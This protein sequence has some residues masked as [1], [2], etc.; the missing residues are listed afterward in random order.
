MWI[1][2]SF[3]HFLC[4]RYERGNFNLDLGSDIDETFDVE[5]R[6]GREMSPDRL[7]PGS[8][9]PGAGG[10]IFA[11]AGQIPGQAND[12]LGPG[13]GLSE[14]LDDPSQRRPHLPRHN[15]LLV[16]LPVAAGLAG[17]D[18]P[19]ARTIDRDAVR[20]AAWLC[21][22]CR[23]QDTHELVLQSL[24]GI[25]ISGRVNRTR[26]TRVRQYHLS[27][28]ATANLDDANPES[29]DSPM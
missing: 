3:G 16:A 24:S 19:S 8:A 1:G 28:S 4:R 7:A 17:K 9:D 6:R 11:A 27:R 15:G 22:F 21:P 25:V 13:P 18:D 5:Q 26:F 23:L 2:W 14:Q 29:R 12:V 20:K 10:F